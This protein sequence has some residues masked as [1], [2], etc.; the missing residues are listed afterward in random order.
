MYNIKFHIYSQWFCLVRHDVFK[1]K[2]P[3]SNFQLYFPILQ[4]LSTIELRTLACYKLFSSIWTGY[5]LLCKIYKTDLFTPWSRVILE[6]ITRFQLVKKFPAFYGTRR[7]ITAFTSVRHLSLSWVSSTQSIAP[8]S[9][10]WKSILILSSHLRLGLQSGLF[11]SGFRT[12]TLYTPL[13][14]PM[15]ATCS[16]HLIFLDYIKL[17]FELF[18]A[19]YPINE[20]TAGT[21]LLLLSSKV[22]YSQKKN[23]YTKTLYSHLT[24]VKYNVSFSMIEWV[25]ACFEETTLASPRVSRSTIFLYSSTRPSY[26]QECLQS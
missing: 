14:S 2:Y 16:V 11:P 25:S 26:S 21:N 3:M 7:F 4:N 5:S 12:K 8:H 19:T 1:R 20:V 6:K 23:K 10:S 17:T 9:T 18:H 13:L 22:L 15:P 24:Y